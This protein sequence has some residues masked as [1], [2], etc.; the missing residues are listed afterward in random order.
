MTQ[1]AITAN[2]L[3]DVITT[4]DTDDECSDEEG[5]GGASDGGE[6]PNAHVKDS[7]E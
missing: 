7:D 5:Y 1:R 6:S 2:E 4:W 3:A